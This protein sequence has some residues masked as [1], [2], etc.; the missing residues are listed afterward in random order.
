[1]PKKLAL[2]YAI[3]MTIAKFV[4]TPTVES[5]VILPPCFSVMI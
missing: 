3:G 4:P 2:A 5:Q 1:M